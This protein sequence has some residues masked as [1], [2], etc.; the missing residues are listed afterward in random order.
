[1]KIPFAIRIIEALFWIPF[2]TICTD[3]CGWV[4][5]YDNS[6]PV[7][8]FAV[9]GDTGWSGLAWVMV[10]IASFG[11]L[12]LGRAACAIWVAPYGKDGM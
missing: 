7:R 2:V 1:M 4:I 5:G 9:I 12:I 3:F 8:I 10:T 11:L 6:L